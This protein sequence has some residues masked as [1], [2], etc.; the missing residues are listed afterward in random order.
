MTND[1]VFLPERLRTGDGYYTIGLK[2][3]VYRGEDTHHTCIGNVLGSI[4]R[5]D[6]LQGAEATSNGELIVPKTELPGY[7]LDKTIR[8]GKYAVIRSLENPGKRIVTPIILEIE[9]LL[10]LPQQTTSHSQHQKCPTLPQRLTNH[11]HNLKQQT[12]LPYLP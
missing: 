9:A 5:R 7:E 1:Q 4:D 3:F 12:R 6:N 11:G 2:G 10:N 8:E